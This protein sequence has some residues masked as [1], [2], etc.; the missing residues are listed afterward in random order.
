MDARLVH[1][2][3]EKSAST[4][5]WL[6]DMGVQ[7][8]DAV[9]YFPTGNATWHRVKPEN[10]KPG[11]RGASIMYKR[12]TERARELGVQILYETPAQHIEMTNGEVT[13]VLAQDK[14]GEDVRVECIA[15]VIATGGFGN[16]PEMIQAPNRIRAREKP[17]L[18]P[19]PGYYG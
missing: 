9:K 19:H 15:A 18:L 13:A 1:D 6:E 11:P 14:S 10:G 7:F 3:L 12:M 17:V 4:I 5:E 16:N 2:Y 8:Y